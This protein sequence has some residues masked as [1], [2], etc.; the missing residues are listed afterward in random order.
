MRKYKYIEVTVKK[1]ININKYCV[2]LY[3][4]NLQV[5]IININFK[6]MMLIDIEEELTCKYIK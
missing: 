3:T 4:T 2:Q 6:T 1:W 5:V